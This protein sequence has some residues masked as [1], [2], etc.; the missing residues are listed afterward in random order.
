MGRE[1]QAA[2]SDATMAAA[3]PVHAPAAAVAHP[4][5]AVSAVA[6]V[7]AAALVVAEAV[8]A[9]VVEAAAV[10]AVVVVAAVVA[11]GGK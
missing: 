2:V 1:V 6:A 3:E 4:V 7:A 8:V 5:W 11:E 9:V 10:A